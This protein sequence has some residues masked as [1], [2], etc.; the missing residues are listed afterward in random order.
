MKT[1]G[2]TTVGLH[3]LKVMIMWQVKWGVFVPEESTHPH[4]PFWDL[5]RRLQAEVCQKGLILGRLL[6]T[7]CCILPFCLRVFSS[8]QTSPY[9]IKVRWLEETVIEMKKSSYTTVDEKMKKYHSIIGQIFNFILALC[10]HQGYT[11]GSRI[12]GTLHIIKDMDNDN[13]CSN[14]Q[15]NYYYYVKKKWNHGKSQRIVN[16]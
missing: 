7:A 14:I 9:C 2:W 11:V 13:L 5:I 16:L 4:Q 12:I 1:P 10:F 6:P 3:C 8:S 15:E